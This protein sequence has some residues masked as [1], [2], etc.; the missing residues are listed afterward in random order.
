MINVLMDHQIFDMQ[1]FGGISRY[2]ANIYHDLQKDVDYNNEISVL[3]TNNYYLKDDNFSKNPFINY[4]L[5]RQKK[6]LKYNR[7]YS[8]QKIAGNNFD[9]FHPTYYD[10][11][12]L[13]DLKKP[14][15][16]TVHDM[17]HEIYPEFFA[18]HDEFA[19]FKRL[20]ITKADHIIA[21]SETTKRD[22]QQFFPIPD[23]KIT[24]VYHGVKTIGQQKKQAAS[25]IEMPYIL[26]IGD[27]FGYKNFYRMIAAFKEVSRLNKDIRLVCTGSP[28]NSVESEFLIRTNLLDKIIY[29]RATDEELSALYQHALF[30]INP[31]LLEGFGFPILEAF[32]NNCMVLLSDSDCFH[33]IA[34]DAAVYFDPLSIEDIAHT[35]LNSIQNKQ[36]KDTLNT[37]GN[38][39]LLKFPLEKSI[40]ETKEVYRKV[41][42]R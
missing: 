15:V 18:P 37:K 5:K 36:Q 22:L 13:G 24:V 29:I 27:R 2:F 14:F 31:S 19:R 25:L 11:Y 16:L 34:G 9:I 42:Q 33:E 35:M 6:Q 41:I 38:L 26:Y 3:K 39:Q 12:F 28:F 23:E 21:I 17:I 8:S 40:Q 30:Y 1:T 10:P 4:R 32:E 7:K 20:T